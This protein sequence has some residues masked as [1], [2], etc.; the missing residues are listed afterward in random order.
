VGSGRE[1]LKTEIRKMI[2]YV[3][4]DLAGELAKVFVED[5]EKNAIP[6][7]EGFF[8]EKREKI[9]EATEG[10]KDVVY[11]KATQKTGETEIIDREE[12]KKLPSDKFE[13]PF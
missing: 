4:V 12:F 6:E 7:Y 8:G 9:L 10:R 3:I 11:A 1:I 2:K 5:E 13:P